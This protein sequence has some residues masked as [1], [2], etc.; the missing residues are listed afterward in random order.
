MLTEPGAGRTRSGRL[1]RPARMALVGVAAGLVVAL[2]LSLVGGGLLDLPDWF[3]GGSSDPGP[4]GEVIYEGQEART[5]S[6]RFLVDIGD[7]E[8]VVSVRAKQDHDRSGWLIDGDFQSTNGTSSVADPVDRGVPARLVVAMDYC[9]DGMI[10]SITPAEGGDGDGSDEIAAVRF[11]MGELYVCEATLEH[12]EAND[13]A[14]KQDDTPNDLHGAFVSFVAR[15]VEAT[16]AASA[17]PDDELAEFRTAEYRDFVRTELADRF[18]L[19][20]DDVEVELAR[21]GRSDEETRD[22]LRERLDSFTSVRDPDDPEARYEA[23][24]FQY[25]AGDGEA[26]ADAC[27]LDPGSRDLDD[28]ASVPAPDPGG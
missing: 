23:L 13:A 8:A 22:E 17:C 11:E 1:L 2:A 25:L 18:G 24:S 21:P 19:A 7:G 16:A 5:A 15:A 10:T 3:G 12:T 14:F 4:R 26:V 28:L 20:E 27:Y 6:E 9:A